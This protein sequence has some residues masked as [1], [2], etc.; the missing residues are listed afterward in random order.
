MAEESRKEPGPESAESLIDDL[1]SDILA[2]AGKSTHA[3]VRGGP[4]AALMEV[5]TASPS[6][7]KSRVSMIERL[8]LAQ[9]ISRC[10]RAC[11]RRDADAGNPEGSGASLGW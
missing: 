5:V 11:T 1:I 4:L 8:L 10:S 2:D 7:S 3:A 9:S 6:R